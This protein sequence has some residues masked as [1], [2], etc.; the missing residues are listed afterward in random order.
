MEIE[1]EKQGKK[2]LKT[3]DSKATIACRRG[4]CI[5]YLF[6]FRKTTSYRAATR[7]EHNIRKI[8]TV[9]VAPASSPPLPRPPHPV[10]R[11][12]ARLTLLSTTTYLSLGKLKSFTRE[13]DIALLP[14]EL[15]KDDAEE[16]IG[17]VR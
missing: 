3:S 4:D 10:L 16:N 8:R 15:K 2:W 13:G 5:F 9:A 17:A 14:V 12:T 11:I 7:R 1:G 6:H